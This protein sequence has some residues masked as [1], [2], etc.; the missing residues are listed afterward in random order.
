VQEEIRFL[1]N[2][3]LLASRLF[4]EQLGDRE[5][6][7]VVGA[8]RF[9]DYSGY[10]STFAFAADHVDR[11]P[12]DGFGRRAT[13]IVAVDALHFRHRRHQYR[14]AAVAR[15]L[16]KALVGFHTDSPST[17]PVAGGSACAKAPGA[18]AAADPPCLIHQAC[19]AVACSTGIPS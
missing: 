9:S 18:P 3:E 14:P 16:N 8:E 1:I 17:Q 2:P 11:S 7:L 4:T 13:Q 10:A 15:E 6:L 12:R 5:A 19:G